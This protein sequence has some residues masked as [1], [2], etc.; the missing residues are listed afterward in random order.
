MQYS[1][2]FTIPR[3]VIG[4]TQSGS[5]KTTIVTGLLAALRERGLTV[6]SFK[7]GPD[8]I[9]PGYH[10]LASG[11]S[12]H[13][14]DTWLTPE[15]VVPAIFAAECEGADI[16]IVEGVMGLYDGGRRGVSSTAAVAKLLD[17]PVL[18][19][20]DAK[21]MGASA[22]AMAQGFRDYDPAVKMAGV[23][24]NR[25]GSDTHEAMIREAMQAAGIT[26][27]GALRR[28]T[29]L[30]MPER[31]LGLLPVQ[32][33]EERQII[34][35]MGKAV[36]QQ[37]DI[38]EVIRLAGKA[39]PL[40]IREKILADEKCT[41]RCRIGVAK[42]EAFSFYYPTSLKVLKQLGAEIVPFSPLHDAK[43]PDVDG[44]IIGGG[45]PEMFAAEL[46]G[47]ES[48]RNDIRK[49]AEAGM[50]IYA[51]C[52][53]YMYLMERLTDFDENSYAMTG[54]F[55][56]QAVMTGKLQMVGYVEAV[57]R[58]DTILGEEGTKIRGHEF[59][60]S[61]E[62]DT[63][64]KERPF[65]FTKLRN[66]MTYGAGQKWRNVLGSYLHLHFAGCPKAAESFVGHC[67]AWK[68]EKEKES[69]DNA[70]I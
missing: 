17:A 60:F 69:D 42:D 41:E 30:Q 67:L 22:A 29:K 21:S 19:V 28:D 68:L 45:F 23:I 52:G 40:T 37:L 27:Y 11:R 54:V 16:A 48:I 49:W 35:K 66:N 70:K 24:L 10:E 4:A 57:L 38:D 63:D 1:N 31:H 34:C 53:G 47:N 65:C 18:L 14:L 15:Q 12:A 59:H 7:V 55:P 2:P 64:E 56:G 9:D 6:Q 26:V 20:I 33:N 8:Y 43:V 51:E 44:L 36:G 50:P 25:L 3:I 5:G 13:N 58:Q 32:E 39:G 62:Q 46:A 61:L